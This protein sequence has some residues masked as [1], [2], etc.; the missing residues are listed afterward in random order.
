MFS[1]QISQGRLTKDP[2]L[3]RKNNG[4]REIVWARYTLAVDRDRKV[5]GKPEADFFVCMVFGKRAEFAAKHFKKAQPVL[6]IGRPT[7]DSYINAD[8]NKVRM[9]TL[10]VWDQRFAGTIRKEQSPERTMSP[11]Q[12]L[13]YRD[14]PDEAAVSGGY[15]G[16]EHI[17]EDFANEQMEAYP[18][19]YEEAYL[20]P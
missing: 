9:Q 18:N 2:E 10:M 11:V 19:Y 15:T 20:N 3:Y 6:V 1:M 7:Q 16:M 12:D 13:V 17:P 8:G 5:E 14:M 4:D